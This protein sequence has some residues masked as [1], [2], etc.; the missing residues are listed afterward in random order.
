MLSIKN[1]FILKNLTNCSDLYL[2]TGTD[3]LG[4]KINLQYVYVKLTATPWLKI[5]VV[6]SITLQKVLSKN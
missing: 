4:T 5:Y 2:S 1:G 6:V 3:A